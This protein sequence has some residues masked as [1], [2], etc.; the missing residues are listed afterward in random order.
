MAVAVAERAGDGVR[1][2]VS[3]AAYRVEEVTW[4][5]SPFEDG[6]SSYPHPQPVSAL[7]RGD[8]VLA[9]IRSDYW[10]GRARHSVVGAKL[11][12]W[13]RF[14]IG[15]PGESGYD[16]HLATDEELRA[17]AREAEEVLAAFGVEA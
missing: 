2:S 10:D 5:V 1:R 3:G 13:R 11:G 6:S 8:A 16:L 12:R 4:P 14:R 15:S 9:D 7:I 17:F